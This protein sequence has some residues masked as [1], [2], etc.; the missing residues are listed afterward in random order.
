MSPA[1]KPWY[2]EAFGRDYLCRYQ[3]RDQ[4]EAC[5]AAELVRTRL[6]LTNS[7]RL[8][9]LCCGAGRHLDCFRKAGLDAVGG[10]L[11]AAL[12]A[13]ARLHDL[14]V[15]RLDMRA[16]PL[17]TCSVD[18]VTNFFTAFGYFETDAENFAVLDEVRRVLRSGGWFVID[19][20]NAHTARESLFEQQDPET[21]VDRRGATWRVTRALSV[22]GLRAE[23]IQERVAGG[24][25]ESRIH[26]SVRLFTREDLEAAL[27]ARGF[28]TRFVWGDYVGAEFTPARSPRLIIAAQL[29]G[30]TP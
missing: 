6:A 18:V 8:F 10:D 5:L 19:F 9:D 23:K 25:T 2:A 13:E 29:Q 22:D 30:A 20:L 1:A 11:S 12:L 4:E 15:V 24:K 28:Q 21:T 16:I 7:T 17:G 27:A 3:H 14:P 26:E